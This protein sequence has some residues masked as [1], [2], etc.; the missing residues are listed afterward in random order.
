MLSKAIGLAVDVHSG[1]YDK[2]GKPYILHPLHIMSFFLYDNELASIAVL[3]DVMEDSDVT[4]YELNEYGFSGR[5]VSALG[6]LTHEKGISYISGYIAGMANNADAIKVKRKDLQHNSDIT[7]LK[8]LRTKDF[9]RLEKY[10]R[11]FTVLGEMKRRLIS[12]GEY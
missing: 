5:V 6:L 3:H 10:H 1:Q 2:G 8:G 9:E 12:R 4:L 11:A 7:R